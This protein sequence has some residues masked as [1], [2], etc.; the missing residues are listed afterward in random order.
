MSVP[1]PPPP[2]PPLLVAPAVAAETG[3]EGVLAPTP[4]P[5]TPAACKGLVSTPPDPPPAYA[6]FTPVIVEY[7]PSPPAP[8]LNPATAA[9]PPVSYTHLTLPTK[10]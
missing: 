7:I 3:A 6:V 1:Q 9:P 10:A 2:P 4:P 5:P 8:V